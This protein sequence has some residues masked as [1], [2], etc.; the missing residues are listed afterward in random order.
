MHAG[1]LG[2]A[3]LMQV[4]VGPRTA[5][6]GAY[7]PLAAMAIRQ[8]YRQ[9]EGRVVMI[10]VRLSTGHHLTLSSILTALHTW[11]LCLGYIHTVV[12]T[13]E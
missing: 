2:S 6:K 7:S 13:L 9:Y 11:V 5:V 12:G 1:K 10:Q 8:M 3:P 4:P